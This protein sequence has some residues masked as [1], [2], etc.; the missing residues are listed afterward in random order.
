MET[1]MMLENKVAVVYGA[2]GAIGGSVARA[3]AEQGALVF[4]TGRDRA[5]VNAVNEAINAAG[6]TSEAATI[7]ALDED[8]IENHL[9]YVVDRTGRVDISFNAIGNTDLDIM[10][11]PLADQDLE[12]FLL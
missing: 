3:F 7:D 11:E 9:G 4:V 8:D 6:G 12:Q 1:T 2:G 10:G 5:P